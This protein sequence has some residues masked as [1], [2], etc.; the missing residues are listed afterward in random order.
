MNKLS[1]EWD[2][3][4][5]CLRV[6]FTNTSGLPAVFAVKSVHLPNENADDPGSVQPHS[7][8]FYEVV[9]ILRGHGTHF[10]NG[11]SAEVGPGTVLL[12]RP[13]LDVHHYEVGDDLVLLNF[14]FTPEILESFSG[15]LREFPGSREF[16]GEPDTGGRRIN[17]AAAA[18]LEI[19]QDEISR[20]LRYPS[21]GSRL[22]V[23]VKL[24]DVLMLILRNL[25]DLPVSGRVG[26]AL[27]PALR[28]MMQNFQEEISVARL[29]R[30]SNLSESSFFRKFRAEL[31]VSPVQWL[32]KY[33]IRRAVELLQRPD[34][35]ISDAAFAAG[36]TDPLYFSRQFRRFAGCSPRTY[37]R[38]IHGMHNV[39]TG[40]GSLTNEYDT[41]FL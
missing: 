1:S 41:P 25:R 29:A 35:L 5:G 30:L 39:I 12:L 24:L 7:H 32:L 14:A 4:R 26:T 9:L 2:A 6:C 11:E 31:G 22:F 15:G 13:D 34:M 3:E 10:R 28:Y 23:T 19:L 36:F 40:T 37:R 18:R 16:F 33:R 17:A 27:E 21:A 20:E 8:H 38:R